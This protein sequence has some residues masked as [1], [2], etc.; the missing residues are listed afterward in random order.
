M[1]I[2]NYRESNPSAKELAI[3]D[4]YLEKTGM[5][6]HNW[7][8]VRKKMGGWFIAAPSFAKDK[9]DGTK[10]WLPYISFSGER[11]NEFYDMLMD[12]VKPLV[13]G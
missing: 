4:I 2:E 12:L 9:E 8:I 6:L 5:T 10:A 1:R 3:F 13:R 7:K 11:K